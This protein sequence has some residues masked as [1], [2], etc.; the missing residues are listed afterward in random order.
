MWKYYIKLYYP[1]NQSLRLIINQ[2]YKFFQDNRIDDISTK[3]HEYCYRPIKAYMTEF[4]VKI[5]I[6]SIEDKSMNKI[7]RFTVTKQKKP[8][9]HREI[10]CYRKC[11]HCKCG[12]WHLRFK[13]SHNNFTEDRGYYSKLMFKGKS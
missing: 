7:E 3:L 10:S 5:Q 12:I 8:R 6:R 13:L 1:K 9:L 2:L 4:P 11:S